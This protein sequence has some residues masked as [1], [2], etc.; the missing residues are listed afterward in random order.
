MGHSEMPIIQP[1]KARTLLSCWRMK[2]G[3]IGATMLVAALL[4]AC[5]SDGDATGGA[6]VD[7]GAAQSD[8]PGSSDPVGGDASEPEAPPMCDV[9][10][11]TAPLTIATD[12]GLVHGTTA[13]ATDAYLGIP[14]STPPVGPRRFAPPDEGTCWTGVREATEYGSNCAQP[15][16]KG[17]EDCLTLNVWTPSARGANASLPVLFWI[18]GGANFTGGSN[19]SLP[20]GN[21]YDGRELAN[22]TNSVVVSFNYRLGALGFLAHPSLSAGTSQGVSGNYGLLDAISALRWVKRNA[23]AF[24][25]DPSRVMVF[26][27]SA[28]AI[29]TCMLVASPLA[30]GLFSAA[31]MESGWCE[32]PRMSERYTQ[33]EDVVKKLGCAD[34][35]DVAAC[36]REVPLDKIVQAEGSLAVSSG[37]LD[38][39]KV[40]LWSLHTLNF[41]PNVDGYVLPDAPLARFAQGKNNHVPVVAGTNSREAALFIPSGTVPSC[42][43]YSALL[44]QGFPEFASELE[45]LYPCD[46]LKLNSGYDRV[47]DIFS[48][49]AF[50]CPTRR[51]LRA[52]SSGQREPVRRYYFTHGLDHGPLAGLGAAHTAELPFVWHTFSSF[53]YTPTSAEVD[54]SRRIQSYW[55]AFAASGDPNVDG[56]PSWPVYD[57][58]H[59]SVLELDTDAVAMQPMG[60][61]R[62]NFWDEHD[63]AP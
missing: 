5:G 32:T 37:P 57:P 1:S 23:R 24:G 50:A 58:S 21:A 28:G 63:K 4:W 29:D 55:G 11:S 52:L 51:A 10:S 43:V 59:E 44:K 17:S 39:G 35:S 45:N 12:R 61:A 16:A 56:A 25:G 62:C 20:L 47:I 53:A 15:A 7:G 6:P 8:G 19:Q 31:L 14:F 27:E 22:A 9:P 41:G 46:A 54:L 60:T 26:G 33:A 42:L 18:Y 3:A 40:D 13:D 2:R 36:L 49:I 48:D 34:A 30:S 38:H